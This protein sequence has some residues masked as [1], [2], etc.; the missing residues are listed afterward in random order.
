MS[1]ERFKHLVMITKPYLTKRCWNR[2]PIEPEQ[3]LAITLRYLASGEACYCIN[4]HTILHLL[5]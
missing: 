5:I 2:I 3:R 4:V 1:P